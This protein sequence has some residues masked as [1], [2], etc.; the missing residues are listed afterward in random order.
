MSTRGS[1]FRPLSAKKLQEKHEGKVSG[2]PGNHVSSNIPP[3][4]MTA[5][6]SI[7]IPKI[8]SGKRGLRAGARDA[9][10]LNQGTK[11]KTKFTG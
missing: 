3:A 5:K 4:H 6:S 8:S 9:F 1:R 10:G 2:V 7:P 11:G